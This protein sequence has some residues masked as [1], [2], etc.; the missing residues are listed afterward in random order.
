MTKPLKLKLVTE[1][2]NTGQFYLATESGEMLPG[3]MGVSI[4]S[5]MEDATVI[6]V[7]FVVNNSTV[8]IEGN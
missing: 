3:Q 6:T 7:Q 4:D 2:R 8:W 5:S 1:R